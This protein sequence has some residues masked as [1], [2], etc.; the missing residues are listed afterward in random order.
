[1]GCNTRSFLVLA[2]LVGLMNLFKAIAC[3]S[4]LVLSTACAPMQARGP[5]DAEVVL[6]KLNACSPPAGQQK[7]S[8]RETLSR[9]PSCME[10]PIRYLL[11]RPATPENLLFLEFLVKMHSF[12]TD[13]VNGL[14][15]E[16]VTAN[17]I[18]QTYLVLSAK[19]KLMNAQRA[20]EAQ[21]VARCRLQLSAGLLSPNQS[22]S[23]GE[24]LTYGMQRY[25][26][27]MAGRQ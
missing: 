15:T 21:G 4:I 3:L 18:R 13:F 7:N 17:R 25:N 10:D 2:K 9:I 23:F 8:L 14:A 6:E 24:G 16:E 5:T 1:M 22:G 26:D 19:E 27:C 11:S 20:A 12:A